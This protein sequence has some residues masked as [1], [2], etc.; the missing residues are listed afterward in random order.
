MRRQLYFTCLLLSLTAF[1]QPT[2]AE[3]AGIQIISQQYHAEGYYA[4]WSDIDSSLHTDSYN[5]NS[6]ESSGVNGVLSYDY[7][8]ASSLARQFYTFASAL[9][10]DAGS[11]ATALITFR[12]V[13]SGWLHADCHLD[14]MWFESFASLTFSDLTAGVTLPTIP[15]ENAPYGY[16]YGDWYLDP[17]HTYSL[18]MS[19]SSPLNDYA[20]ANADLSF[21]PE[22]AALLLLG[23]GGLLLRRRR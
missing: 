19:A 3:I 5:L 10:L 1:I 23:I 18:T 8:Y 13:T 22:P 4:V 21:V 6:P 12:P 15:M 7:A 14:G 11:S 2:L 9:S 20:S 17:T 16:S